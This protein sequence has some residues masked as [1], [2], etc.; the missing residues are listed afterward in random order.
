MKTKKIPKDSGLPLYLVSPEIREKNA[1]PASWKKLVLYV[2]EEKLSHKSAPTQYIV[3]YDALV[4]SP[5]PSN[6]YYE[7]LVETEYSGRRR[8]KSEEEYLFV[9]TKENKFRSV[10][11]SQKTL[12]KWTLIKTIV[13]KEEI[14]SILA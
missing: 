11:Y 9:L 13:E 5:I 6:L 4:D 1:V 7:G 10:H 12:E 3:G 14:Q 8:V 2:F